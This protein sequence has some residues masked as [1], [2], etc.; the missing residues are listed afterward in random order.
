MASAN[1]TVDV[2]SATLSSIAAAVKSM[3]RPNLLRMMVLD[4]DTK[5]VA[6][7]EGLHPITLYQKS[8]LKIEK[9]KVPFLHKRGS[10]E[11][12][13]GAYLARFGHKTVALKCFETEL[14]SRSAVCA[15]CEELWAPTHERET[16]E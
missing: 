1:L 2:Q 5:M 14:T 12:C 11:C 7:V 6:D 4:Y 9:W 16:I 8:T 13:S 15:H 10:E 3:D